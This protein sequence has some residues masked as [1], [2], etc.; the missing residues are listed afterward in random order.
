MKKKIFISSVLALA[1]LFTACF[2]LGPTIMLKKL[3]NIDTETDYPY[4]EY[5]T[6]DYSTI[7]ENFFKNQEVL[8]QNG[9]ETSVYSHIIDNTDD[10]FVD[11]LYIKPTENQTNLICFSTGVHGIE[12]YIGSVMIQVFLDEILDTIDIS[13][14]G[15]VIVSNVNPYGV[16]Y[17]RRFNENNVDLNRN[18]IYD[19]DNFDLSINKDYPKV[20]DFLEPNNKIG[21]MFTNDTSFFA[22]LGYQAVT[23]GV[24]T[25]T[26]ALLGG[27]YEYP[28]GVYYGG[29][30]DENSTDFLKQVFD[31]IIDSDFENILYFDIHSGYGSRYD[32]TIF[33]SAFDTL[34]EQESKDAYNYDTV[35]SYDSDTFYATTGDTTEYFYNINTDKELYATCFE[36]GTLGDDLISSVFSLKYTIEENQNNKYPTNNETSQE[37]IDARYMEMFFPSEIKWREN[38]VTSFKKAMNGVL[39]YKLK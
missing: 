10:L 33:N 12:S 36:F 34:T 2:A 26:N 19:W 38:A 30:S 21:N 13:N 18:F 17:A 5:F 14:T 4:K 28:Q 22:K 29:V 25:V 16:K 31:N 11:T 7:R 35:I 37:I 15:V 32:M 3:N 24:E 8:E 6:T 27:Q 1:G 39:E 9:Y 23:N 20:V